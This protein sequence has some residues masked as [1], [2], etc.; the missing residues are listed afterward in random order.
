MN[1]VNLKFNSFTIGEDPIT[2][3]KISKNSTIVIGNGDYKCE[4]IQG[5][6]ICLMSFDG[7]FSS[8]IFESA[9]INEKTIK[10]ENIGTVQ[11][12]RI[13]FIGRSE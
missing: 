10:L 4:L 6:E 2:D 5:D 11:L 1:N 9:D 3:I 7:Y 13:L 12:N 8:D